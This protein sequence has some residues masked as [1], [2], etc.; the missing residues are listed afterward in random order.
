MRIQKFASFVILAFILAS[1]SFLSA[2]GDFDT[3]AETDSIQSKET[4]LGAYR[5]PPNYVGVY[6]ARGSYG[7]YCLSPYTLIAGN[8]VLPAYRTPTCGNAVGELGEDCDTDDMK[9][10][11]CESFGFNAGNLKCNADCSYNTSDCANVP[12]PIVCGNGI[13]EAGEDCD[14]ADLDGSS[15]GSL[16][17]DVGVLI[18][19]ADCT[20]DTSDC[21]MLPPPPVC[22]NGVIEA[23]ETCDAGNFGGQTCLTNGFMGG[24]LSCVAC[25]IS[26][27]SCVSAPAAKTMC[28]ATNNDAYGASQ[29]CQDWAFQVGC[30]EGVNTKLCSSSW[31]TCQAG[32]CLSK[33]P[34]SGNAS[35]P[36]SEKTCTGVKAY[37]VF[38]S[39]FGLAHTCKTVDGNDICLPEFM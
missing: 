2:C 17:F 24:S 3:N 37:S 13:T 9:G 12:P 5:C 11:T 7:C 22:G 1:G 34:C 36:F 14:G 20:L 31:W 29:E 15:C 10:R 25:N 27:A 23:G 32:T 38:M 35:T 28:S 16:G 30:L 4:A 18:C 6:S 33:E 26:T 19:N 8:C 21:A 39:E